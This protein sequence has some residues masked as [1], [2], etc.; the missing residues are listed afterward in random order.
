M[1]IFVWIVLAFI[2][3]FIGSS[4]K[5]GFGWAFFWSLL[6]PLIGFIVALSSSKLEDIEFKKQTLEALNNQNKKPV[7][8]KPSATVSPVNEKPINDA[9]I[10]ITGIKSLGQ[11]TID[12]VNKI[13]IGRKLY[14]VFEKDSKY[15]TNSISII[16]V[17][18]DYN[19]IGYI[20]KDRCLQVKNSLKS[21]GSYLKVTVSDIVFNETTPE[22]YIRVVKSLF[23][24]EDEE[25]SYKMKLHLIT[26]NVMD[27]KK[28]QEKIQNYNLQEL[29][30]RAELFMSRE[31]YDYAAQLLNQFILDGM[32]TQYSCALLCKVYHLQKRYDDE[33]KVL[34]IWMSMLS[35]DQ[36]DE[37]LTLTKRRETLLNEKNNG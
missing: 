22:L 9:V 30:E 7:D 27:K 2:G 34:D 12:Y 15:D 33:I 17:T 4:R 5:I 35:K 11:E 31:Q 25:R 36:G 21:P 13:E 28:A 18:D 29:T 23:L 1:W 20:P 19:H 37:F 8:S 16:V 14:L 6:C 24:D 32:Q 26:K 3:G 10:K